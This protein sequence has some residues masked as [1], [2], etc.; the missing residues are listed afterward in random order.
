MG[1]VLSYSQHYPKP[2]GHPITD[3]IVRS[4]NEFTTYSAFAVAI[5]AFLLGAQKKM[6]EP[7]VKPAVRR[8]LDVMR[9][10]AFASQSEH[11]QHYQRVTLFKARWFC[12]RACLSF[13][14]PFGIWLVPFSRSGPNE[15]SAAHFK[16]SADVDKAEGIAGCAFARDMT[17]VVENLPNVT[18][19][20]IGEKALLQYARLAF[21][22]VEWVRKKRPKSRSL[23]GLPVRVGG[24]VWGVLVLDSRDTQFAE[25]E[26]II[27]SVQLG[28]R[29]L[30]TILE[31]N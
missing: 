2:G 1:A 18:K 17:M 14:Q 10:D 23:I 24:K 4:L 6:R 8:T 31:R 25:Y 13:R 16:V 7:W 20:N 29:L 3:D 11:L 9:E 21:V 12:W 19:S 28:A 15:R 26:S 22:D 30:T 27:K 5:G